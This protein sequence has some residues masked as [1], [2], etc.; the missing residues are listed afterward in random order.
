M[1][2]DGHLVNDADVSDQ[3]KTRPVCVVAIIASERPLAFVGH[4]L[5]P[6][7]LAKVADG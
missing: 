1:I 7:S 3:T 4:V 2:L 6:D 5:L